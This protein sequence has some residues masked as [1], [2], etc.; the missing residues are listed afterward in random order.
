MKIAVVAPPWE[1]IPPSSYGGIEVVVDQLARGFHQAGHEVLLVATGDSTSPVPRRAT[2]D[3]AEES[4]LGM[5]PE[6]MHVAAAYEGLDEFDV[7]HDHTMTGPFY[8]SPN[9]DQVVVTTAH[10]PIDGELRSIYAQLR[11][12]VELIAISEDQAR[13]APDVAVT[14]VIHHGVDL[15]LFPMGAGDGDYV[16]FLGRMS[17]DKGAHRAIAAAREAGVDVL[18][19]AKCREDDEREYFEEFVEPHL[20]NGVSYIGEVSHD[21]KVELLAGARAL[22]FPIRWREPFGMVMIEALACGTPVLAFP[23]GSVPEIVDD[24]TTGFVCADET[25][26]ADAIHRL[27]QLDRRACRAS[28]ADR[29]STA[30]MVEKHLELF[31]T[32]TERRKRQRPDAGAGD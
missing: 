25:E 3:S 1:S 15:D 18:V 12:R 6:L 7:V 13:S 30:R 19:V 11:G 2:L 10:G 22:L 27:D 5:V 20:G 14:A 21:R 8:A 31:E 16:V 23:E 4:Q 26:M 24:G 32:L 17:P 29:F 28:V 9:P